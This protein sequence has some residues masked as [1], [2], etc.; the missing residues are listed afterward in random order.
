MVDVVHAVT[1]LVALVAMVVLTRVLV[2][3]LPDAP[4]DAPL[5]PPAQGVRPAGGLGALSPVDL[6]APEIGAAEEE[7]DFAMASS[8]ADA[9]TASEGSDHYDSVLHDDDWMDQH[10][11]LAFDSFEAFSAFESDSSFFDSDSGSHDWCSDSTSSLT[12]ITSGAALVWNDSYNGHSAW[13]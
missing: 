7:S 13:D 12:D 4:R 10:D 3:L 2:G 5:A 1:G 6:Y 11:C 8:E 9:W